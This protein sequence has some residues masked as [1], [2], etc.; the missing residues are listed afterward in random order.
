MTEP[1]VHPVGVRHPVEGWRASGALSR[2]SDDELAHLAAKAT[3]A[4]QDFAAGALSNEDLTYVVIALA[5]ALLVVI[6]VVAK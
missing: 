1:G 4:E 2:L 6:I 3:G 5:A